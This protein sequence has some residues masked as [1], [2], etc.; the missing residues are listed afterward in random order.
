ME[1]IKEKEELLDLME[2]NLNI[3]ERSMD[4]YLKLDTSPFSIFRSIGKS[5]KEL[6]NEY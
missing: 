6:F 3:R 5:I 4:S 2:S 1:L